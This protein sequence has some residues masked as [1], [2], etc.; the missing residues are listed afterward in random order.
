MKLLPENLNSDPYPPHLTI[1]YTCKVTTALRVCN[2]K[3]IHFFFF[4]N[5][6]EFFSQDYWNRLNYVK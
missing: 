6:L 1:T 5:L 4:S 2:G 3:E